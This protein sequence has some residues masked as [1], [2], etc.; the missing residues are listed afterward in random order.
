MHRYIH[1]FI[2]YLVTKLK[3]VKGQGEIALHKGLTINFGGGRGLKMPIWLNLPCILC[4]PP[5]TKHL[6]FCD[7]LKK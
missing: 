2:V 6:K 5:I 3:M 1:G 7:P 4:D